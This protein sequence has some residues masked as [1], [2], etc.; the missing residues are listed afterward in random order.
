MAQNTKNPSEIKAIAIGLLLILLIG[1][2]F[3]GQTWWRNKQTNEATYNNLA[4]EASLENYPTITP[5]SLQKIIRSPEEKF[6]LIDIRGAVEYELSHIPNSLSYPERTLLDVNLGSTQKI[7][8]VGDNTNEGTNL[9]VAKFLEEEKIPYAF[10]KGGHAAWASLNEQVITTG[11][12]NSFVD[13]SKVQ[14]IT[15]EELKTRFTAGE[16]FLVLDVQSK[17]RFAQKHLKEA[18]NIPL[19][20]LESRIAEVPTGKKI[21]VYG[22]SDAESFQAGITLFDLNVFSALVISGNNILAPESGLFTEGSGQ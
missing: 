16:K 8:V 9:A 6:T 12:P 11:D 14:Y 19:I 2:Y 7:I 22:Q 18:V 5:E 3:F 20:E 1:I 4:T 21:V 13:Q 17:E 15:A 10:L